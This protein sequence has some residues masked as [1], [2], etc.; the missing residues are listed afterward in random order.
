MC[1]IIPFP[2]PVTN[3][4]EGDIF[5]PLASITPDLFPHFQIWVGS[6]HALLEAHVQRQWL[7]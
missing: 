7:R 2:A 5:N 3:E 4:D 6:G 1:E